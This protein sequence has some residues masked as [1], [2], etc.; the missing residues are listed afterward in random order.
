MSRVVSGG[1]KDLAVGKEFI[2]QIRVGQVVKRGV[3]V[4]GEGEAGGG[5][6]VQ[7]ECGAASCPRDIFSRFCRFFSSSRIGSSMSKVVHITLGD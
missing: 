2:A 5:G 1:V 6:G 3:A 7:C 4:E